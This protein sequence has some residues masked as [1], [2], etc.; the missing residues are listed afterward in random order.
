V[1]EG[2]EQ[3]SAGEP[4]LVKMRHYYLLRPNHQHE[5][6]SDFYKVR[7][8]LH[9]ALTHTHGHLLRAMTGVVEA[10][11]DRLNRTCARKA[12]AVKKFSHGVGT[13]T[14]TSTEA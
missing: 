13:C 4:E 9:S 5:S 12:P 10:R 3:A 2:K 8:R 14:G 11:G 6:A 7:G 1:A